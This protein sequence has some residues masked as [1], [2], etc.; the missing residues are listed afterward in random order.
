MAQVVQVLALI[1]WRQ[2]F[3]KPTRVFRT[4]TFWLALGIVLILP[5]APV[6]GC[7]TPATRAFG[8]CWS[9]VAVRH[10]AACRVRQVKE[11]V[12]I[13]LRK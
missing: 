11:P 6:R 8:P 4:P 10:P 2:H 12:Y 3:A 7:T 1:P 9:V 13:F 5:V